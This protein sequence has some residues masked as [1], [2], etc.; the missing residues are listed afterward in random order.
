MTILMYTRSWCGDCHR[1]K[2]L[3]DDFAIAYDEIELETQ[4]EKQAD[5]EALNGGRNRV[6]TI[7]FPDRTILVEP[8]NA[9]LAA[10]VGV[11]LR[12]WS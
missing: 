11:D 6:P 3:L 4:P 5:M 10:K 1:A 7:L 12:D 9:A 2:K 8:S